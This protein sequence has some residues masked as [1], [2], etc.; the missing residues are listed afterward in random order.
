VS[1]SFL[2]RSAGRPRRAACVPSPIPVCC[3]ESMSQSAPAN[4]APGADFSTLVSISFGFCV[5]KFL[6]GWI[7]RGPRRRFPGFHLSAVF[8][9]I[10]DGNAL[11]ANVSI[12]LCR[13]PDMHALRTVESSLD[14]SPNHNFARR[15]MSAFTLA[16]GPTVSTA[17]RNVI[18]PSTFPSM[19]RSSLPVI[20]PLNPD[21]RAQRCNA[22]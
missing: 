3:Q 22:V 9:A 2:R 10:F 15:S 14:A 11:R 19:N 20:S 18:F 16:F 1:A 21:A 4:A 17:L 7:V 5:I 6:R 13:I 12:H 8:R